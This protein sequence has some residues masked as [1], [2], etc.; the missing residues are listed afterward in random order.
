MKQEY[1]IMKKLSWQVFYSYNS[2]DLFNVIVMRFIYS[3]LEETIS[4]K[5]NVALQLA[6]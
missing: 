5:D 1:E 2:Y 3:L 4:W 6:D